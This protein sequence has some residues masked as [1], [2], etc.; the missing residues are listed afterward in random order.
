MPPEPAASSA[1]VTASLSR[2]LLFALA[3]SGAF[4]RAVT[5]SAAGRGAS[6][7]LARRYVAGPE[8][9]DAVRCSHELAAQELAASID[10]FGER[11]GDSRRA[12]AVADSYLELA[13]RLPEMPPG[14]WLS[15]DLS[16][17]ALARDPAGA[18]RRLD[19]VVAALPAGARLQVGAEEAALTDAVLDPVLA[20]S[21]PS[22]LSATLQANLRRSV[23]D[24]ERLAGAG[25]AVRLVKGAYVED[26]AA[27][28][29]YGEP[30]DVAYLRLA[31]RLAERG[32]E[33]FLAT[34]HGLLLEACRQALPR[35]PVEMLLGVRP[36]LARRLAAR[37]DVAVRVY[38]PYGPDWFR[39]GMRRFAESRGA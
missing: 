1:T 31:R 25:I 5:R 18:R 23:A 13:G 14:T 27:A 2:R 10:L 19:R 28:L 9:G 12:D 26:R 32:A 39:Y 36:D 24:A 21:E 8:L 38:V 6:W 30:T 7:R 11:T 34:H 3:T 29:P 33:V 35:A 20:A 22:R 37:G 15:V 4:E 17:F 16:H